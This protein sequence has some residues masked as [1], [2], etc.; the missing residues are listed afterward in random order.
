MRTNNVEM[1]VG[2]LR[3]LPTALPRERSGRKSYLAELALVTKGLQHVFSECV[4]L[5][6]FGLRPM[7]QYI[8]LSL[9]PTCLH[10][11]NICLFQVRRRSKCMPRYLTFGGI[12][13]LLTFT[14]GYVSLHK[15]N[16]TC[17]DLVSLV[18]R[19]LVFN[20]FLTSCILFKRS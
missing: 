2:L 4:V 10:L 17:I 1:A 7:S 20:Q 14:G 8:W 12:W 13:Q 18:L 16:V 11:V 19:R 5:R 6:N 3:S 9:Y 15:V